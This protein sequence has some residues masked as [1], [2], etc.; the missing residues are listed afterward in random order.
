MIKFFL[1]GGGQ[2][3]L[4]APDVAAIEFRPNRGKAKF[5][6]AWIASTRLH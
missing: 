6:N 2:R 3:D 5:I 4:F 1:S